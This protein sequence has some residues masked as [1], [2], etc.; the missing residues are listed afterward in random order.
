MKI[1][2]Y[3]R[4]FETFDFKEPL[5]LQFLAIAEGKETLKFY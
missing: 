3:D 2:I 1:K 4:V 5:D